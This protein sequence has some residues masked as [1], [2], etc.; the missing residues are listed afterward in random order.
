VEIKGS[1]ITI[2]SNDIEAAGQ[3]AGNIERATKLTGKDR[4]IFQDGIFI[5]SKCGRAI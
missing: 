1:E 3:T 5:T 2:S 4:R